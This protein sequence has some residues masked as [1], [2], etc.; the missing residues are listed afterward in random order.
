MEKSIVNVSSFEFHEE[1]LTKKIYEKRC[2]SKVTA[3]NSID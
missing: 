2:T 3:A 1:F